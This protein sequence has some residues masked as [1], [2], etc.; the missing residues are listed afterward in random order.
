VLAPKPGQSATVLVALANTAGIRMNRSAGK[1]MK[2]PPP[3]N[4]F[5]APAIPAAKN[6]KIA[7]PKWRLIGAGKPGSRKPEK[8]IVADIGL[9][10]TLENLRLNLHPDLHSRLQSDLYSDLY[11]HLPL[12]LQL[13]WH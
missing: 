10:F 3:A 4:A 7:C 2:L 9:R 1:E 12:N 6:K 5:N 13:H 8:E 11:S